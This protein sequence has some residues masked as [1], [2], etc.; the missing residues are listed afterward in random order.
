ML[1]RMRD[2]MFSSAVP[3]CVPSKACFEHLEVGGVRRLDRDDHELDAEV[4]G[5]APGVGDRAL[6]GVARRV[7]DADDVLRAE[8]VGGD[9]GDEAGVDAAGDADEHGLEAV[10]VH[11]VARAGDERAGRPR[12]RRRGERRRSPAAAA[13]ACRGVDGASET[14]TSSTWLSGGVEGFGSGAGGCAGGRGRGASRSRSATSRCSSKAGRVGDELAV[15]VEDHAVAVED[16][17]VLAADEVD[18]ADDRRR[19]RRRGW[20]PCAR[21]SSACRGGRARR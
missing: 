6:G 11:V 16:E 21:G 8:G 15:L 2:W 7:R 18:V 19:C 14:K 12:P 5:E 13:P 9:G 20:R 10:L 1:P 4:V 17:L 3:G